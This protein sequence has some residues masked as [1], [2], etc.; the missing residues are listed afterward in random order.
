MSAGNRPPPATSELYLCA[1]RRSDARLKPAVGRAFAPPRVSLRP[2][3]VPSP[4]PPS[5]LS[6][7]AAVARVR[8]TAG[9]GHGA[10]NRSD[11]RLS[12][13]VPGGGGRGGV[14]AS[15]DGH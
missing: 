9:T 1:R 2:R 13:S 12:A 5:P 15:V 14:T 4:S 8:L 10:E 3:P 6:A 7:V 11:A